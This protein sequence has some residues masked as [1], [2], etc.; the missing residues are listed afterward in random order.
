MT[1]KLCFANEKNKLRHL[2][3][4]LGYLVPLLI[5]FTFDVSYS[6]AQGVHWM[7]EQGGD[8]APQDFADGSPYLIASTNR[9][10]HAFN[11]QPLHLNDEVLQASNENWSDPILLF[12][13]EGTGELHY[14]FV[15][16]DSY[17]NVHIFVNLRG[18]SPDGFDKIYYMRLDAAGWSIPVDIVVGVVVSDINVVIGRDDFIYLTWRGFGDVISYSR[19]PI[20]EAESVKNWSTPVQITS[21]AGFYSDI[22][23]SPDGDIYLAYPGGGGSGVFLQVFELN[24]LAWS[25][26]KAVAQTSQINTGSDYVEVAVSESGVLHVVWTE[27]YRPDNWPPRGIFYA[28]SMDGGNTWS[29]PMLLAGDGYDQASIAMLD[30]NVHVAWNGM[31]TVGGRYHRWSSDGGQTWSETIDVVPAGTGG[32]EGAPQIVGDQSGV[33]HMLTTYTK[34]CPWYTY[35]AKQRWAIPVCIKALDSDY[36][37]E[38]GLAISEGNRLHAVFWEDRKRLWY[39]TKTTDAFWIPPD[40]MDDGLTQSTPNPIPNAFPIATPTVSSINLPFYQQLD[41]S[42][43]FNFSAGQMLVLSL[44][45]VIL[46]LVAIMVLQ[47]IKKKR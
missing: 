31:V 4:H 42:S 22:A 16:S 29:V 36:V 9:S 27:F 46:L 11:A 45:P 41:D 5:L 33:L 10:V 7:A 44:S 47:F 1:V 3:F 2:K 15:I 43:W 37:E 25:L 6:G 40:V 34:G 19:V 38:T 32:T 21:A 30:E 18:G 23:S 35:F 17:G 28:R 39:S 20:Q 26:P 24:K 12:E 14:P 13:V 8:S